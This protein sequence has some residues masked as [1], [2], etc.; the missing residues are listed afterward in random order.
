L[1]TE[2]PDLLKTILSIGFVWTYND[3]TAS[4]G[5]SLRTST[6]FLASSVTPIFKMQILPRF[7]IHLGR[8]EK[9]QICGNHSNLRRNAGG[10][11]ML[12]NPSQEML[13]IEDPKARILEGSRIRDLRSLSFVIT[14][15][16]TS[17]LLSR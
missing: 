8:L 9:V 7:P 12:L 16:I 14:E 6:S 11:N 1:R 10:E 15:N 13:I 3:R 5:N 2:N 4:A 17:I